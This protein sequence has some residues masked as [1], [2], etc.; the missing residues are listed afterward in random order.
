MKLNDCLFGFGLGLIAVSVLYL[1]TDSRPR[2]HWQREAV[3]AGHAHYDQMTGE[4]QWNK[5]CGEQPR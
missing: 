3:H 4:F 5:P 1:L 2:S